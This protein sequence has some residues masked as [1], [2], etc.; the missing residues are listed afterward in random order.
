MNDKRIEAYLRKSTRVLWGRKREEVHEELSVHIQGRVTAH[1]IGGLS[2][3]DAIEKTLTELGH[4][5][6]VS[7]GMA[8]LYT[9]PVVA[10]SGMVLAMCC[11]VVVVLLS[12]STAQTLQVTNI[13]PADECENVKTTNEEFTG[14]MVSEVWI[15]T[16]ALEPA[17]GPQGVNVSKEY[18]MTVLEFPS[19]K[20]FPLSSNF[21]Y[22]EIEGKQVSPRSGYIRF[23]D[24]IQGLNSRQDASV[25]VK[26]WEKPELQVDS[27]SI[28]MVNGETPLSGADFYPAFLQNYIWTIN[29]TDTTS[30]WATFDPQ[31]EED[32]ERFR[33]AQ[34]NIGGKEGEVYGI[35]ATKKPTNLYFSDTSDL[36]TFSYYLD[37]A[38]ADTNGRVIFQV[39]TEEFTFSDQLN[40]FGTAIVIGLSGEI[41]KGGMYEVI[42]PD[43]IKL[44]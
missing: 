28:S 6:N 13:F 44:E 16:K 37:A 34:L 24:F 31:G 12:G 27:I 33:T 36:L 17:L 39:P 19:G 11:A 18:N 38:P 22:A 9:L 15:D 20:T 5:T 29:S 21:G 8:R 2:E 42:P 10:G 26:G 32:K 4:P 25:V 41:P 35:I 43:Q 14:C 7:A 1:L 23:G 3:S 30:S 40:E